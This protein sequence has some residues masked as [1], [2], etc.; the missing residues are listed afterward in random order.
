MASGLCA[1]SSMWYCCSAFMGN[2]E[3]S[4]GLK[5]TSSFS[6]Q[7]RISCFTF[8]LSDNGRISNKGFLKANFQKLF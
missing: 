6:L 7:L 4:S 2:V 5:K 3:D 1:S 8:Q